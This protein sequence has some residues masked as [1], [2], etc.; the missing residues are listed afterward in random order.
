[1][2]AHTA[3]A[4]SSRLRST[5]SASTTAIGSPTKRTASV[6]QRRPGEVGVHRDEAVVR[7][8]AEVVGGEHGDDA[9]HAGGV[10]DVDRADRAVGDL[11]ADEHGVQRFDEWQVGEV[12]PRPGE[13]AGILGAQHPACR[14]SNPVGAWQT[15]GGR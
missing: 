13:Q 4:A 10:V 15:A 6:G 11:G 7:R 14:G 5:V 1:M 3:S 2:S 12:L 8:D 9:G